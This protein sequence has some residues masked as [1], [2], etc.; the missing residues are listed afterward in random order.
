MVMQKAYA[1]VFYPIDTTGAS[2]IK[3]FA[4]NLAVTLG[5]SLV[6]HVAIDSPLQ[7]LLGRRQ[8]DGSQQGW[9]RFLQAC[10][11]YTYFTVLV[12]SLVC[13]TALVVLIGRW[14]PDET[15]YNHLGPNATA[16]ALFASSGG[17]A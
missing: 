4:F 11:C 9:R 17:A 3:Y 15:S 1:T 14:E 5:A 6:L 2:F 8:A 10:T 7:A 13:H 16:E 12:I